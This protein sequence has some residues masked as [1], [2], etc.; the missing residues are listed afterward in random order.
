MTVSPNR[1]LY[2]KLAGS[3]LLAAVGLALL[4][5]AAFFALELRH[6]SRKTANQLE[7]LLDTVEPT[8]S[9][10]AYIDN[11]DMGYDVLARLLRNDLIY[12]VHLVNHR[13][14]DLRR[15]RDGASSE[16]VDAVREL[17]APDGGDALVGRLLVTANRDYVLRETL[18]TA[19]LNT[20]SSSVLIALTT[21]VVLV[22]V[23]S[24]LSRPL[25]TV[26][27]T[28]HA[29]TT[30]ERESLAPLPSHRDDE[31][32]RLVEDINRLLDR[33]R[34]RS[35]AEQQLLTYALN[36]VDDSVF[37]I[38][39]DAGFRYVNEGA[40]RGLGYRREELL[41]M[42]V[43]DIDPVFPRENWPRIWQEVRE[44]GSATFET[45]HRTRDGRAYPVEIT[46]DAFE[47][48]GT[49]YNLALTRDITERKN[50]EAELQRYRH[51]LEE[52][53]AERTSE[54]TEAKAAAESASQA[55]GRFLANMSHEIRTPMNAILGLTYLLEKT[56]LS[57]RQRDYAEKITAAGRALLGII[58][59]ILDFSKVE[60]GKIV[61]DHAPFRLDEVLRNL[62]VVLSGNAQ[63]QDNE[64]LFRV[65]PETPLDLVGDALRLEQVLINLAGNAVKFTSHGEVVVS[66]RPQQ[67][68]ADTVT[69][70]FS[71]R[72]TGIGIA[73]DQLA[74]IFDGFTQAEASTSRRFGGTG[75]GLA[76][77]TRLV[78]L[79]GGCITVDST[80][81]VGSD[82]RFSVAFARASGPAR[83]PPQLPDLRVLV[84][85][86]HPTAREV[87]A[88]MVES[89]GWHAELAETGEKALVRLADRHRPGCDL[90][91]LDWRLPGIS[92]GETARRI[93]QFPADR[94]P[95]V[96][97][98]TAHGRD[99]AAEVGELPDGF[100]TK[101]AT[102]SMLLD[103]VAD[104]TGG[105]AV[106][107]CPQATGRRLAG[108]RVLLAEDNPINQQV[109]REILEAEG[110]SV[111]VAGHGGE[112][113]ARVCRAQP[114]Y[115][116]VL[117]DVQMPEV[118]GH[119]ATREL[120]A[121]GYRA[122]PIIAM[123]ANAM[124]SDRE[125]CLASGMDD[126][127]AKPI[128]VEQLVATLA[129]H[130]GLAEPA[131]PAAAG[132]VAE[133]IAGGAAEPAE[134][135]VELDA[136]LLRMGGERGLYGRI[137]RQFV[138]DQAEAPGL[139]RQQL[140]QG[141]R[142]DARRLAHT[143]KGL[144]ATVG[145]T[146]LARSTA[147]LEQA[148][149]AG[150]AETVL[151][152]RLAEVGRDLAQALP[153]LERLADEFDPPAGA[154][155]RPAEIDVAALMAG[156]ET[157]ARLLADND[158]AAADCLESFAGGFPEAAGER[159]AA[160]RAALGRLDLPAARTECGALR[161][162]LG[163]AGGV[164]AEP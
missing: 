13:A 95:W 159:V 71:I 107:P 69:L 144:A 31:L 25:M 133:E 36:H 141:R 76:I 40:C 130:C 73:A 88:E 158:L 142:P 109:A 103:A 64:V 80:P 50:A 161:Q 123:T 11:P 101:P 77:C 74:S 58:N 137:C 91:L 110:A 147:E 57:A 30:G 21:L 129:R 65:A 83:S 105:R 96:I 68:E 126:H 32:G 18:T 112:A 120:R 118:D 38:D 42:T 5:S 139:I 149:D 8:A 34:E 121:Q 124:A 90:V 117:M 72:D 28:L 63:D 100:L 1:Y 85:D 98:V 135:I 15:S 143:L 111:E 14:V 43:F 154:I 93:R 55:K 4:S 41:A 94:R 145:A 79:M 113:V 115:D 163:S 3:V 146:G 136:A 62:A 127:V 56:E 49:P 53:V 48:E 84:V 156:L 104:I 23:R 164:G 35:A 70:G 2:R 151:S 17:R 66:V 81:G 27:D 54:L 97:V 92:G 99:A 155:E 9:I 114:L 75:L 67:V 125:E 22:I 152:E 59:D 44:R 6:S 87:M 102:A 128:D 86:D 106:R 33:L 134:G 26:S 19:L 7:Q 131:G 153:E 138:Q 45:L 78:E 157:L 16:Q 46:A 20:G 29:I 150:A 37:V 148:I 52:L 47:F 61:L 140:A 89:L 39:R 12:Q 162:W 24:S 10:A 122:L 116:A 160:L 60:A 119:Q 51:H 108:L 82:F 132:V